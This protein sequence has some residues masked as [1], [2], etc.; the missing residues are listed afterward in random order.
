MRPFPASCWAQV[1]LPPPLLSPTERGVLLCS[2]TTHLLFPFH[3][4][5]VFIFSNST[6]PQLLNAAHASCLV[7]NFSSCCFLCCSKRGT[8]SQ[9]CCLF[10]GG[11]AA[12]FQLFPKYV[13]KKKTLFFKHSISFSSTLDSVNDSQRGRKLSPYL[14]SQAPTGNYSKKKNKSAN[15]SAF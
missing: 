5:V 14:L 1:S 9:S 13:Q 6:K 8:E 2:P 4:G 7:N 10:H 15:N 11:T 12:L 3:A